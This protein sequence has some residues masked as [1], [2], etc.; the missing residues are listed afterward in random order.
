MAVD[1]R[2][3]NLY[4]N[5]RGFIVQYTD[6]IQ[7]LER[8]VV[9][10]KQDRTDKY[11]LFREGDNLMRLTY[12]FYRDIVQNPARYWWLIADRNN[13][14]DPFEKTK[15]V[16]DANNGFIG[17]VINLEN[18]EIVIPNVLTQQPEI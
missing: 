15:V 10:P 12:G 7:I 6:E 17:D 4:A 2:D 5:P 13:V 8:R 18:Q 11:M 3:S 16:I 1:L 14:Y 9:P